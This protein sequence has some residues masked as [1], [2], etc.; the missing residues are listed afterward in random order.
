MR[1]EE[2]RPARSD[3][4]GKATRVSRIAGVFARKAEHVIP[5]E[6]VGVWHLVVIVTVPDIASVMSR[7]GPVDCN[8]D[9]TPH[10]FDGVPRSY[11]QF[12]T[13]NLTVHVPIHVAD[14]EPALFLRRPSDARDVRDVVRHHPSTSLKQCAGRGNESP[15]ETAKGGRETELRVNKGMRP[16]DSQGG[17]RLSRQLGKVSRWEQRVKR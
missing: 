16:T 2:R 6:V 14:C 17:K 4:Q 8:F 15:P 7:C 11:A 1:G 9:N 12:I 13:G 5:R 3:W 10:G